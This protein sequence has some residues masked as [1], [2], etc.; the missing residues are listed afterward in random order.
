MGSIECAACSSNKYSLAV[1]LRL[2][3]KTGYSKGEGQPGSPTNGVSQS[4][5]LQAERSRVQL[6]MGSLGH[7]LT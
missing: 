2:D 4:T 6:P 3:Y 7:L 5:A 1:H